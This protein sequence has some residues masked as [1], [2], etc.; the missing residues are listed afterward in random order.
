MSIFALWRYWCLLVLPAVLLTACAKP[1]NT[2]SSADRSTAATPSAAAETSAAAADERLGTAW[3]DERDSRVTT[4]NLERV[5]DVLSSV[6]VYYSGGDKSARGTK[7]NSI[8]LLAGQV[9]FSIIDDN[10]KPL[11]TY[12]QGSDYAVQGKAG[13][14]Y[15]LKYVNSSNKT[16]EVIASVD[17]LDVLSGTQASQYNSGYVLSPKETLIIDGFRKDTNTVASFTFSA[18]ED[19]YANHNTQGDINNTGV[20]GTAFFELRE[21]KHTEPKSFAPPPNTTPNPKPKAFP[22]DS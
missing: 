20:I 8:S 3:G 5:G 12:R 2:N 22:A 19:S 7:I 10:G 18:P 1:S 16:Y 14:S 9:Q 11:P 15:R 13:Q 21:P 6:S 17:G 4:V